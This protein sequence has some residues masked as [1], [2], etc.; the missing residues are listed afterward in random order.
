[1]DEL[2]MRQFLAM[3]LQEHTFISVPIS[4]EE[5][6]WTKVWQVLPKQEKVVAV[7][8]FE[9]EEQGLYDISVQPCEQWRPL[10]SDPGNLGDHLDIFMVEDPIQDRCPF[11]LRR[12]SCSTTRL[13]AV[14]G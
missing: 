4:G 7:K 2:L 8:H 1:M 9:S 3:S 11:S 12:W 5:G 13:A 10:S 6:V 14:A